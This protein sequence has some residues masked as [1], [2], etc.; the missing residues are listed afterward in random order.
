MRRR[1]RD[2]DFSGD[3]TVDLYQL[4]EGQVGLTFVVVLSKKDLGRILGH[5]P[6]NVKIDP[7]KISISFCEPE[8]PA[9]FDTDTG[10]YYISLCFEG[11]R[12]LR[13]GKLAV[14]NNMIEDVPFTIITCLERDKQDISH[15]L[16]GILHR[17]LKESTQEHQL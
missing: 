17:I 6:I 8:K 3:L 2:H 11:V 14:I 13:E 15:R 16:R 7:L 10:M 1:R 5:N 4:E 12:L 9:L